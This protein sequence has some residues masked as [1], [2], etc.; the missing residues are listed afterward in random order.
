MKRV[1]SASLCLLMAWLSA[2]AAPITR[3]QALQKATAFM[4]ER[5]WVNQKTLS[6]IA[7]PRRAASNGANS[8][9]YVFNAPDN[10]GFVI[11]SGDDRT[12]PVI[13][14]AEGG[15]FDEATI[16][17][18][19][20]GWL[21]NIEEEIQWIQDNDVQVVSV[22]KVPSHNAISP[23]LSSKWGQ[24]APYNGLCPS[25][26]PT[27]CL[28][29][30][31]AQVM[32]YHKWPNQTLEAIPGYTTYTTHKRLNSLPVTTFDWSSMSDTY[33]GGTNN[34]VAKL[35]QYVGYSVEMDYATN[36]SGAS[37]KTLPTVMKKYFDYSNSTALAYRENYSI[38][39]W[40]QLVYGELAAGRP[41]VYCGQSMGGGHAFV[42]D[43]YDGN[44]LYHINWGWD[45]YYDNYFRL[46]ILNPGTT[47]A[48]GSSEVPDGFTMYQST[49]IGFK[50]PESGDNATPVVQ[51]DAMTISGTYITVK[52]SGYK[53]DYLVGLAELNEDGSFNMKFS[54]K[55]SPNSFTSV[56][57]YRFS[58][59]S[60]GLSAAG[61]Y[62]LVPVYRINEDDEFVRFA[63][64]SYYVEADIDS[65]NNVVLTNHPITD[66]AVENMHFTGSVG[67]NKM[68]QLDYT[69]INHADEFNGML[70]LF[71][72]TTKGNSAE[73]IAYATVALEAEETQNLSFW[74]MPSK[75]DDVT[76]TIATDD[77]GKKVIGS[78]MLESFN[79]EEVSST[80]RYNPLSV[81]IEIKN[82]S[83]VDYD[84]T[85]VAYLY[86]DGKSKAIG[87]V[88][89]EQVIKAGET[90]T[91]VYNT[92]NLS[93][94][95]TY[96]MKFAYQKNVFSST[97]V[98]LPSEIIIDWQDN[99]PTVIKQVVSNDDASTDKW[100]STEG[101][102]VAAALSKGVY[103]H[104]GKKYVK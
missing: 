34:A 38:E 84:R 89:K 14:Y 56:G 44:G 58:F 96:K 101:V 12:E 78:Y 18:N 49:L 36:G 7:T 16:P 98:D 88:R 19:M 63:K 64:T 26:C 90:S 9:T 62:I 97:L 61:K 51:L 55:V 103:I 68:S 69:I 104:N 37:E 99:N 65:N 32:Y 40:D 91:F 5:G 76:L 81:S 54:S 53:N 46:S 83:S 23:L 21:A 33:D 13:G 77:S 100:Y 20:K 4:M 93:E 47:T 27:G 95:N 31:V 92:F 74:F 43:G 22:H 29:T 42:C 86:Q 11:L 48:I 87:T 39:S 2:S 102:R 72:G 30:A 45:G 10:K 8:L 60:L 71:D 52:T 24:D 15:S 35:M 57:S 94:K 25:G 59:S 6:K 70:Y 82:N 79:L 1:L 50:K 28:A 85:F 3:T 17:V 67:L 75:L 66:L 80:V 41:V 73:P